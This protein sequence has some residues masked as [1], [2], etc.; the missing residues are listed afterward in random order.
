MRAF[1][2]AHALVCRM[3]DPEKCQRFISSEKTR[4]WISM[5]LKGTAE[6][7]WP[8]TSFQNTLSFATS[9]P[10]RMSARF[11]DGNCASHSSRLLEPPFAHVALPFIFSAARDLM[12]FIERLGG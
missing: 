10:S 4:E 9:C 6:C 2:N 12:R 1:S 8:V 3:K 5:P 11:F 7:T